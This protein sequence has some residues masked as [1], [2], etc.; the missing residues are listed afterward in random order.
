VDRDFC[1]EVFFH[2]YATT[3]ICRKEWSI[4]PSSSDWFG[5]HKL[6]AAIGSILT[7]WFIKLAY[8]F[9]YTV[10][11]QHDGGTKVTSETN[12]HKRV[13]ETVIISTS[14][15]PRGLRESDYMIELGLVWERWSSQLN[16]FQ[17][18]EAGRGS[19]RRCLIHDQF[20]C[21]QQHDRPS[22]DFASQWSE[23]GKEERKV[24]CTN[25]LML[26]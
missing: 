5:W 1:R 16:L 6:K 12:D 8:V 23:N 26:C 22:S 7:K 24:G 19:E 2:S 3:R 14:D 21:W 9:S 20:N 4:I 25:W 15:P 10:A 17:D 13:W 11:L 18:R